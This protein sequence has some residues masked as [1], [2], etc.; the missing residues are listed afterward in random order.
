MRRKC[1]RAPLELLRTTAALQRQ[2]E[3]HVSLVQVDVSQ[4]LLINVV[5][6]ALTSYMN[7]NYDSVSDGLPDACRSARRRSRS[8]PYQ[9]EE[10]ESEQRERREEA[11]RTTERRCASGSCSR[12]PGRPS[13]R[14]PCCSA[15]TATAGLLPAGLLSLPL[16]L[17]PSIPF[18][19]N[20]LVIHCCILAIFRTK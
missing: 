8:R 4:W 16:L 12:S 20:F 10:A 11:A 17:L 13:S 9:L 19:E 6:E 2:L 18:L 14:S 3:L 1:S 15:A 7:S 5:V